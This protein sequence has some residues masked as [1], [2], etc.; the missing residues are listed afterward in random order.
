MLLS[1][2][3]QQTDCSSIQSAWEVVPRNQP[4][5]NQET[6][7][8]H[9]ISNP[10]RQPECFPLLLASLQWRNNSSVQQQEVPVVGAHPA[11]AYAREKSSPACPEPRGT[12]LGQVSS[13]Q[14]ALLGRFW[15]HIP[16]E[17]DHR[18]GV[19]ALHDSAAGHDHIGT[20]LEDTKQ[21]PA[22]WYRAQ[23]LPAAGFET[24]QAGTPG[25]CANTWDTGETPLTMTLNRVQKTQLF[26]K[27]V[28]SSS[29]CSYSHQHKRNK[30][31]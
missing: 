10:E 18:P 20:C 11:L 17:V 19:C 26:P 4:P 9:C 28:M 21:T 22:Q 6:G 3:K 5:Q 25:C 1:S 15:T 27:Y 7:S 31:L 23:P 30:L 29:H 24:L 2:S 16:E 12:G 8:N 14:A 13:I